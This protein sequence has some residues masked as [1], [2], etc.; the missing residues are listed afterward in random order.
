LTRPRR[1]QR[2]EQ[3]ARAAGFDQ[4]IPKPVIGR[5]VLE[6]LRRQSGMSRDAH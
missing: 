3:R 6:A 1:R 5:A 4:V 2:V